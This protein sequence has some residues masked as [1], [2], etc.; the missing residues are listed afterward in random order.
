[1]QKIISF[2]TDG[3]KKNFF[4]LL[5]EELE[6]GW[7]VVETTLIVFANDERVM[8]VIEKD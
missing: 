7:H 3:F 4:D 6:K 8:V 1:M 2:Y 5:N